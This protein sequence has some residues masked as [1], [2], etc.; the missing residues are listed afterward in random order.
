MNRREFLRMG[1]SAGM[2]A[3]LP[4][5]SRANAKNQNDGNT[6]KPNLVIVHTDEQNFRTLGCYRKLLSKDQAFVWG[7][8]V[9]VETPY[10]DKLAE[11]GALCSSFYAASPVCT[12]SR[13]SFVSGLYPYA[14]GAGNNHEA[15]NDNVVTFGEVLRKNGYSTSYVGKWHLDGNEKPGFAPQRK[16]GFED[17][18]YMINRG[19]WKMF[20]EDEN[21]FDFIGKFSPDKNKYKYELKDFNETNYATDFLTDRTLE[22]IERD[23]KKPFCVMLSIPDPHDPNNVRA[24][25][26]KMYDDLEVQTPRTM[27][28]ALE[29]TPK[30]NSMK[31]KNAMKNMSSYLAKQYFGMVK[32]IDD[33]L[34]KLM[35]RLDELNLSKNTI[36]VFTSD[37]GE[38]LGE[39]AKKN[40]GL[41]FEASACVPFIIRYP[42]NI[43]PGKLIRKAYTTT[44][45]TP[46]ILGMM[47]VDHKDYNFHGEDLSKDFTGQES[48]LLD[49]RVVYYRHAGGQWVAAVNSR[50]KLI[51]ASTYLDQEPVLYDLEKDPDELKNFYEDPAYKSI[52]DKMSAQLKQKM[53]QFKEPK[54]DFISV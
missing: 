24:P 4:M 49:D 6:A 23:Q 20:K 54:I 26:N 32:C 11:Q 5:T 43:R 29:S 47:G 39:H 25:Y 14:T 46:S 41:P 3:G 48:E 36:L 7:D 2:A 8:G 27:T 35:K 51:F 22:I 50:Y 10:A 42:E 52:A 28:A 13:A 9:N 1:L 12:P 19:H 53:N 21:G 30:W 33:N 45:F 16:F 31:S 34:G 38:M 40:K 18:R 44:D 37:H 17:N 15:L